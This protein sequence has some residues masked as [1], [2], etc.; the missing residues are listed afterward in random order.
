VVGCCEY[1]DELSGCGTTEL[2]SYGCNGYL[3]TFGTTA[4]QQNNYNKKPP[5][6]LLTSIYDS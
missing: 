1:G 6:L 3:Q 4:L 5:P 2:V